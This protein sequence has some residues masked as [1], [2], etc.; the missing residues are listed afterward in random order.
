MYDETLS[1]DGVPQP[2]DPSAEDFCVSKSNYAAKPEPFNKMS[3]IPVSLSLAGKSETDN[4]KITR[5]QVKSNLFCFDVSRSLCDS[6]LIGVKLAAT[7][8]G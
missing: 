6:F 2:P 1:S 5:L 4:E 8:K 7:F 3:P